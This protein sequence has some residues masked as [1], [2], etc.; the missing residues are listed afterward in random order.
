MR[1]RIE[2][3]TQVS[4]LLWSN[5]LRPGRSLLYDLLAHGA[6]ELGQQLHGYEG[7]SGA[8]DVMRNLF[9]LAA[10]LHKRMACSGKD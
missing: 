3:T 10:C 1:L 4:E 2:V 6:P 7:Y 5:V 9:Y 8:L